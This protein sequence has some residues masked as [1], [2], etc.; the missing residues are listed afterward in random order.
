MAWLSAGV[1]HKG[2]ISHQQCAAVAPLDDL[3][4]IGHF[5]HMVTGYSAVAPL[6]HIAQRIPHKGHFD[7][8][9][10]YQAGEGVVVG[11]DNGKLIARRFHGVEVADGGGFHGVTSDLNLVAGTATLLGFG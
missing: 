7:T 9:G 8:C 2:H 10:F 3:G 6:N 1:G 5:I 11:S 4:V